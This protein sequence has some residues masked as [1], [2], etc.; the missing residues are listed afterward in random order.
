MQMNPFQPLHILEP[1]HYSLQRTQRSI[2]H[3][4]VL[5]GQILA[6]LHKHRSPVMRIF[7]KSDRVHNILKISYDLNVIATAHFIDEVVHDESFVG[8]V[9]VLPVLLHILSKENG[10]HL[11]YA[12]AA[13]FV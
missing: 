2:Q 13:S 3:L 10:C 9:D 1:L 7:M 11:A 6:Y 12:C 8:L 5:L 4:L